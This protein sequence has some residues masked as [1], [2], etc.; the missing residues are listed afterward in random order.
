M[1]ANIVEVQKT[2]G[3]W[4]LSAADQL[5]VLG[6]PANFSPSQH[7]LLS[8]EDRERVEARCSC[9][10]SLDLALDVL[11][12]S[13]ELINRWLIQPSSHPLFAHHTPLELLKPG[14]LDKFRRIAQ[15]MTA[16]SAGNY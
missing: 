10:L 9:V 16:W 7:H 8:E 2:L 11:Y 4:G 1:L 6:L 15:L 13:Q 5:A 12:P 3:R 14:D